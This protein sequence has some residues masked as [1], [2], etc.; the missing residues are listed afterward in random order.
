MLGVSLSF[1][2]DGQSLLSGTQERPAG[3]GTNEK[4][5]GVAVIFD[6]VGNGLPYDSRQT[7]IP[8][9]ASNFGDGYGSAVCLSANG[10]TA[11]VELLVAEMIRGVLL[12]LAGVNREGSSHSYK[13]LVKSWLVSC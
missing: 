3:D 8:S 7:L 4:V 9:T 13:I 12:F 11:A 10:L 5:P 2:S 1:S 6:R